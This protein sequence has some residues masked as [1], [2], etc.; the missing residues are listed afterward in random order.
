VESKVLKQRIVAFR[1]G[2]RCNSMRAKK[3]F[4]SRRGAGFD[5]M[6]HMETPL[7]PTPIGRVKA[8]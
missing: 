6:E 7:A 3:S 4:Q 2:A 1:Y 5:T 8:L